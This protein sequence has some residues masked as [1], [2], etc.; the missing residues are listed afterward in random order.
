MR[1]FRLHGR[2]AYRYHYRYDHAE[3]TA[4]LGMPSRTWP[5]RILFNDDRMVDDARRFIRLLHSPSP[6]SCD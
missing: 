6:R 5:N 1:Y 2:P 3:L 4:L